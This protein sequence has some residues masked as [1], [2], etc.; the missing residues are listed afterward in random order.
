[1]NE[2][3]ENPG[4]FARLAV[5]WRVFRDPQLAVQVAAIPP[6]GSAL[7]ATP[8]ETQPVILKEATPEAALQILGLLQKEGRLVDFLQEDVSAYSDADIG[9]A[10][11]V[12]HGGCRKVLADY[13]EL[14]AVRGEAEGSRVTLA[15]GYD[16]AANRV[17]GQVAGEPPFSGTLAHRGWRVTDLHLPKL[18]EG[19]DVRILAPAEIEL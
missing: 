15:P 13:L 9:A 6:G 16:A 4:F 7:P 12:V 8:A 18:V 3:Q 1:M 19:H 2:Q 14:E 5:A 11:R 17:T 10:A